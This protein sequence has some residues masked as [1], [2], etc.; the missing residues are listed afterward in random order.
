VFV[1]FKHE[2]QGLGP[3]FA[4]RFITATREA[5]GSGAE[6]PGADPG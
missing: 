5:A 4:R 6:I 2:E 1:Y 3:D